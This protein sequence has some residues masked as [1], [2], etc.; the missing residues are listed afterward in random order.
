VV[1]LSIIFYKQSKRIFPINWSYWTQRHSFSLRQSVHCG[2]FQVLLVDV[3]TQEQHVLYVSRWLAVDEDDHQ[4]IRELPV[5]RSL[6]AADT[7]PG[8]TARPLTATLSL[9]TL[10]KQF[11]GTR[12]VR[13]FCWKSEQKFM[14]TSKTVFL[15]H[16]GNSSSYPVG[17]VCLCV[18]LVYCIAKR[19]FWYEGYHWGKRHLPG[20]SK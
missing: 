18:T 6:A 8:M 13:P 19:W 1:S 17:C 15:A 16:H 10:V 4:I 9:C 11:I 7:L 3:H 5:R 20:V 12:R 2:C 14:Y